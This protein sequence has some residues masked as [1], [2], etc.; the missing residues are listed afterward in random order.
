MGQA[1]RGRV[2]PGSLSL[3]RLYPIVDAET[4]RSRGIALDHYVAELRDAG[5]TLLQYRDKTGSQEEILRNA[6]IIA[7]LFRGIEST[8]ILNDDPVL[9]MLSDWNAVH[10]GQGDTKIGDAR[11]VLPPEGLIGC[12]T[13]IDQQVA[14]ADVAGADYIAIGPVF[15]TSTKADA[16]PVVGLEGVR[17]ARLLT[18]RPLVA[19]GGI[20]VENARAVIEAG[21]D[22]VAV[23]S[24]LIRNDAT[25]GEMVA[26]FMEEISA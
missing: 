11:V 21:A 7:D 12:S 6:R 23:I 14:E 18:S 10:V 20:A 24:A 1:L 9:A 26:R 22:S 8:L 19:I 16:E 5:V 13:H 25:P 15:A 3:P 4:L 2:P 17:S